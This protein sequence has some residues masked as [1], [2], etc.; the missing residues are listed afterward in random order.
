METALSEFRK[1]ME[2]G[3]K[4]AYTIMG[5]QKGN[6]QDF[7]RVLR[8]RDEGVGLHVEFPEVTEKRI[9]YQFYTDPFPGLKNEVDHKN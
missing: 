5:F 7:A 1:I 9:V 6:T 4:E 3:L 8:Q 2:K